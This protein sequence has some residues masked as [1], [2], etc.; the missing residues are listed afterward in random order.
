MPDA[1]FTA[2]SYASSREPGK[3]RL[4]GQF[5]KLHVDQ[6]ETF[7]KISLYKAWRPKKMDSNEYLI[8]N[9]QSRYIVTAVATQGR[10]AAREYVTLYALQYSDNGMNWFYYTDENKIITVIFRIIDKIFKIF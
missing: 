1:S 5:G 2:T 7:V 6:D 4:R 3:A 10:R 9:L 8:I